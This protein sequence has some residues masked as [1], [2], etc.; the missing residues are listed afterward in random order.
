[1]TSLRSMVTSSMSVKRRP[2]SLPGRRR[3]SSLGSW[4]HGL[5]DAAPFCWVGRLQEVLEL[6]EQGVG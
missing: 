1:M 4:V 6:A 2:Y 3:Y 5:V